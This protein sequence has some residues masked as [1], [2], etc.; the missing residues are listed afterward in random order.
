[1]FKKIFGV[2]NRESLLKEAME[3]AYK[4]LDEDREMFRSAV[5]FVL[6]GEKSPVDPRQKDKEVNRYEIDI[7]RKILEHLAINPKQDV[8]ASLV[9]LGV[10]RD[11]ERIGDVCKNIFELKYKCSSSFED[12]H[13]TAVLKETAEKLLE[14]F[15]LTID[16]FKSC[17]TEKAEVVISLHYKTVAKKMEEL[18]GALM[19]E[20]KM[21]P[22]AA[23]S[24]ALLARYLKRVSANLMNISSSVVNPFD[25]IR[26]RL[27]GTE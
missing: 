17:D 6:F 19:E 8:T 9:L 4:M 16:A 20:K 18:I 27:N 26:F 7:R 14:M 25:R 15:D 22:G 10:S 13:Y 2:W 11:I 3:T 5:R 12:N 21:N 1:M 23:V 24:S